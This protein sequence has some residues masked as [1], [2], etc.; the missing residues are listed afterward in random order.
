MKNPACGWTQKQDLNVQFPIRNNED[1]S[2]RSLK[3]K[4]EN[5]ELSKHLWSCSRLKIFK[6][7]DL[8]FL[9]WIFIVVVSFWLHRSVSS[10]PICRTT[11]TTGSVCTLSRAWWCSSKRGPT[12]RCRPSLPSSWLKSIS[13]CSPLRETPSGRWD[14]EAE[15]RPHRLSPV[16][17]PDWMPKS[18]N[19]PLKIGLVLFSLLLGKAYI[20]F[21]GVL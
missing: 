15:I 2:H 19:A 11:G 12:W 6:N 13:A 17:V 18:S 10:W 9:Y 1:L 20:V 4:Q 3:S 5:I 14:T 7:L 21:F 16:S 8:C